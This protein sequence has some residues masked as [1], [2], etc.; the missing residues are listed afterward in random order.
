MPV[1][2]ASWRPFKGLWETW[3]TRAEGMWARQTP[4]S[5]SV[6]GFLT[7]L[8]W[9]RARVRPPCARPSWKYK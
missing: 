5:P 9:G 4:P 7:V 6:G 2:G 3:G 1:G 8:G